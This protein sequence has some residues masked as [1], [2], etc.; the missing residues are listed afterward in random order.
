MAKSAKE[1]KTTDIEKTILTELRAYEDASSK[2]RD[3]W[4]ELWKL[5]IGELPPSKHKSLSR[6]FIPKVHQ[7][8]ETTASF[9]VGNEPSI[10]VVPVG[11]DDDDKA[12]FMG[13]L[14]EFQWQHVLRMKP[15]ILSWVKSAIL[16]GVGIMKVGWDADADEPFAYPV[17]LGDVF[18]DPFERDIQRKESFHERI[19]L[20]VKDVKKRYGVSDLK[21]M[22]ATASSQR[23]SN[24]F[25]SHDI[26]STQEIPRVELF[27][28]WTLKDVT[29]Y[30]LQGADEGKRVSVLKTRKNSYG[31]I[32]YVSVHYKDS[33]LP[34]RFYTIGEIEPVRRVQMRMN[35]LINQI[36]DNV[37]LILSPAAKVRRGSAIDP[38]ELVIFPSRVI[39]MNNLAEDL[40]FVTIPDTTG[41]GFQLYRAL[42][43][44]FQKGTAITDLRLGSTNARTATEVQAEQA[45]LNTTTTLVKENVEYAVGQI[46]Q[47]LA[48]LNIKNI[49]SVRSIRIFDPDDVFEFESLTSRRRVD[50]VTG[51][52]MPMTPA[53]RLDIER[54]GRIFKIDKGN[55]DGEYDIRVKADSTLLQN[56]SVLR[57]QLTDYIQFLTSIG[58][59]VDV[60]KATRIWGDLSGIPNAEQLIRQE[61]Q[62]T[63]GPSVGPGGGQ[64]M[65]PTPTSRSVGLTDR[66]QGYQA[67]VNQP[68]ALTQ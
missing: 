17:N 57:K 54:V 59:Q 18:T 43:L 4:E 12:R 31:V 26:D 46:G 48:A 7:A 65:N 40:E 56:R 42:D 8:V 66:A 39:H 33:P 63:V 51:G 37:N 9:L 20:P 11:E 45:N 6:N 60:K 44:E 24:M 21:P 28:R 29:T 38:R 16:F 35:Q 10:I 47:M 68:S 23:D 36:V 13:R 53:E 22:T 3:M 5:Y 32:P 30:A 50:P 67:Q 62:I 2:Q 27:E 41:T 55:L 52:P 14:L 1:E 34:N 19:V 49:T 61:P 64:S 15:K 25:D 58:V